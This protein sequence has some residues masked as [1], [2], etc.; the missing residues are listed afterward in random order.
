[1]TSIAKMEHAIVRIAYRDNSIDNWRLG[2]DCANYKVCGGTVPA[3][4]FLGNEGEWL[5]WYNLA[6]IQCWW[7]TDHID[8]E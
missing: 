8:G 5:G 6:D 1:M 4:V 2:K 7:V 3:L